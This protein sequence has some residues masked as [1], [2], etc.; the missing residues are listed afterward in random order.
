MN[1][2]QKKL[3]YESVAVTFVATSLLAGVVW[4]IS[5]EGGG[6]DGDSPVVIIGGS[7]TFKAPYNNWTASTTD[8]GYTVDPQYQIGTIAVKAR[9]DPDPAAP[10]DGSDPNKDRP[11]DHK[12]KTDAISVDVSH[13]NS[14]EVDEYTAT[15][16]DLS[17]P[18]VVITSLPSTSSP[19]SYPIKLALKSGASLCPTSNK[20]LGY[21]DATS[22]T[23]PD[24]NIVF[25]MVRIKLDTGAGLKDAGILGCF[26]KN[27]KEGICRVVFRQ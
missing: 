5:A 4:F 16:T 9:S 22:A 6:G 7:L 17:I 1:Q 15:D 26:D 20:R 24:P 19:P 18:S 3:V 10:T 2:E 12:A 8:T 25:T 11:D 14:W 27:G 23:C 21:R 13:A